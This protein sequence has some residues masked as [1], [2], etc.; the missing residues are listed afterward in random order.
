MMKLTAI[1]LALTTTLTAGASVA[2]AGTYTGNICEVSLRGPDGYRGTHGYLLA[3]VPASAPYT[4]CAS[5]FKFVYVCSQGA[6]SGDCD[7][8]GLHTPESLA[9]A[10]D[11]LTTSLVQGLRVRAEWYVGAHAR[12]II[13]LLGD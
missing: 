5:G 11:L 3:R 10:A 4:S 9:I 8:S 13:T 1:A 6:T 2:A 12:R 7:P